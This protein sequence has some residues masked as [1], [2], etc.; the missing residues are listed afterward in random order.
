M[1]DLVNDVTVLTTKVTGI[2]QNYLNSGVFSCGSVDHKGLFE[3]QIND[4]TEHAY[5]LRNIINL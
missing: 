1:L 4:L 5:L 2:Q 3:V